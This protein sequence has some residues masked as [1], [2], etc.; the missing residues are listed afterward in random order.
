MVKARV[1]LIVWLKHTRESRALEKIGHLLY[2]SRRMKYAVIYVNESEVNQKIQQLK[3]LPFVTR[4]E[5]SYMH[6]V[7]VHY[8][9]NTTQEQ[10]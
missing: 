7:P 9:P 4:V 6:E 3:K 8:G 5:R 10:A 2:L 1:G